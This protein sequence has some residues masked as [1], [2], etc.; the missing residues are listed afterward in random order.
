MSC[1]PGPRLLRFRRRGPA[2]VRPGPAA[3]MT[4]RAETLRSDLR[5][6]T[7]DGVFFSVMVGLGEAYVPAFALALGQGA[8]AAGLLATL[9]LLAGACFQLVTPVA[10]RWLRSYRRWVVA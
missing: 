5:Q 1:A 9:P 7:A 6:M 8:T 10:V 4:L 3:R 2:C